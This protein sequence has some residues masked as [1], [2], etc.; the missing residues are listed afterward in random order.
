[1][2]NLSSLKSKAVLTLPVS[3]SSASINF[4]PMISDSVLPDLDS[5]ALLCL[6]FNDTRKKLFHIK[7]YRQDIEAHIICGLG[8]RKETMSPRFQDHIL[9][10]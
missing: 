10:I 6:K 1:M 7:W 4:C 9:L 2:L 8:F 3:L 5:D